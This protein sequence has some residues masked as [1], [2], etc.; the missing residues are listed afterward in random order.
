MWMGNGGENAILH[1]DEYENILF[2]ITGYK[3][4]RMYK[5]AHGEYL[6]ED[7]KYV[8]RASPIDMANPDLKTYPLFK[9]VMDHGYE[10]ILQPGDALYIPVYWFHEVHSSC[11]TVAVNVNWD[12]KLIEED[13]RSGKGKSS[14]DL[15]LGL[16]Q[17]NSTCEVVN[18]WEAQMGFR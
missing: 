9:K 2:L 15:V 3:H 18:E 7:T 12:T 14:V 6:Y 1:N 11:R 16:M 5:P 17:K 4:V 13:I 10:V 8:S